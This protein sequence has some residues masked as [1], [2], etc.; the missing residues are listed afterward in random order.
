VTAA[1][2][3][4]LDA[5]RFPPWVDN[6]KQIE[7]Q[8]TYLDWA[9]APARRDPGKPPKEGALSP[10]EGRERARRNAHS[11]RTGF[12][13]AVSKGWI[14]M[15][16]SALRSPARS[17]LTTEVN[18]GSNLPGELGTQ[19]DALVAGGAMAS[20][21]SFLQEHIG[22]KALERA[23]R[24]WNIAARKPV[25]V[26]AL[27][28]APC[29]VQLHV[30]KRNGILYKQFYLPATLDSPA[31]HAEGLVGLKTMPQLLD[32][33]RQ[34]QDAHELMV[35]LLEGHVFSLSRPTLS[36][37]AHVARRLASSRSDLQSP[38]RVLLEAI[39]A[40]GCAAFLDEFAFTV[41]MA[42]KRVDVDDLA[43]GKTSVPMF[44]AD[45]PRSD[46][47]SVS[48]RDLLWSA[49]GTEFQHALRAA[50]EFVDA[51]RHQ[52]VS[53][54]RDLFVRHLP[55][56]VLSAYAALGDGVILG[57]VASD[58]RLDQTPGESP[59]S[60]RNLLLQFGN[61]AMSVVLWDTFRHKFASIKP[62]IEAAA[63]AQRNIAAVGSQ[64]P[65][66]NA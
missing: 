32:Q 8:A 56:N 33:V 26:E 46:A 24:D 21:V 62:R 51:A 12:Q 28:P 49:R 50:G 25:P 65:G 13:A 35:A 31:R 48:W 41:A 42:L 1:F 37:L 58:N 66:A 20:L 38:L 64:G 36:G 19:A 40:S 18:P 5:L 29:E 57:S 14:A 39:A 3:R 2:E 16:G 63:L 17:A 43:G 59:Q 10:L 54:L 27:H 44:T 15:W 22:Q 34:K 6:E 52:P 11:R 60:A 47:G 7:L 23:A 30:F 45:H 61:S 55:A 9:N 53:L 4:K